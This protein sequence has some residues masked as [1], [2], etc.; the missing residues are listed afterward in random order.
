M[1]LKNQ[2]VLFRFIQHHLRRSKRSFRNKDK[3]HRSVKRK[4]LFNLKTY[5]EQT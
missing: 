4:E 5:V 1:I 2:E 3:Y